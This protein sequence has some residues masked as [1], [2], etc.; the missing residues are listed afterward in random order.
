VP[1]SQSEEDGQVGLAPATVLYEVGRSTMT[2][3]KQQNALEL[4]DRRSKPC[5]TKYE[6]GGAPPRSGNDE[7]PR[8]S[9]VDG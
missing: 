8:S 3:A 5:C 2:T 6:Y 9:S 7:Q 1:L 4:L